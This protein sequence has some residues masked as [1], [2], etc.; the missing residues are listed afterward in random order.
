MA[1]R[2]GL[3][4]GMDIL[5]D[6]N[7]S[8]NQSS[9][10]LRISEVEPNKS[11]PRRDFDDEAILSL[12]NSIQQHGILQPLVVRPL[13]NGQYQIV[14]GERRWR[15]ARMAGLSE[16][17]VIIKELSDKETMQLALIENLQRENLNPVEEALGYRDLM[18]EYDMTQEQ[19]ASTVNKSRSQIGNCLRI[20]NLEEV[21]LEMLRKGE[22]SLGHAKVL[23]SIEDEKLQTELA[24]QTVKQEW[25][26]RALEK[27]I[28]KLGEEKPQE[29]IKKNV[30]TTPTIH[31]E[32]ELA[33]TEVMGRKVK[34]QSKGGKNYLQL[35][36][37]DEEDLKELAEKISLGN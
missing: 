28:K 12:C 13:P 32:V 14:A 37:Y 19:V 26:V 17:P 23:V 9:Q 20:L 2:K 7:V 10:T 34:V 22:I 21:P 35:E 15:A 8:E 27:A 18:S 6:D 1:A 25:S 11:Q 36:F 5:Y 30:F 4:N 29:E 24:E 16:V 33:L 3:G 31:K